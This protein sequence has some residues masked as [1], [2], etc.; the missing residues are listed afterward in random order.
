MLSKII[1]EPSRPVSELDIRPSELLIVRSDMVNCFSLDK[2]S[3]S[4][5]YIKVIENIAVYGMYR[6]IHSA[7]SR[8]SGE[9][10]T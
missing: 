9:E 1:C 8:L 3:A 5:L 2:S 7:Q 6:N 10:R 4:T